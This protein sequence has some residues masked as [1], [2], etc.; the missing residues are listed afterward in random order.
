MSHELRAI[1]ERFAILALIPLPQK[2][3][4][5]DH[6]HP[7]KREFLL[8][9]SKS[10]AFSFLSETK[11]RRSCGGQGEPSWSTRPIHPVR[12]NGGRLSV[13][14]DRW[15]YPFDQSKDVGS[16]RHFFLSKMDK[17]AHKVRQSLPTQI[18]SNGK[19]IRF[20]VFQ[21]AK[22]TKKA[23]KKSIFEPQKWTKSRKCSQASPYLSFR[24]MLIFRKN[25]CFKESIQKTPQTLGALGD[26]RDR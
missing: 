6:K 16:N 2:E 9:F 22:A 13:E 4:I 8:L 24:K 20:A 21:H 25:T 5:L 12:P 19:K 14:T 11:R 7:L 26:F 17:T 3:Q 18:F 15:S 10:N 1:G 23:C